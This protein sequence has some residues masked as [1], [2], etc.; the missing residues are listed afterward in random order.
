MSDEVLKVVIICIALVVIA[1][2]VLVGYIFSTKMFYRSNEDVEYLKQGLKR[3]QEQCND[4]YARYRD[5]SNK[6]IEKTK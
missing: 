2:I 5:L 3:M 4:M 1:I 6:Y